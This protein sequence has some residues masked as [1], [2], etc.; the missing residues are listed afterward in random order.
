M[1]KWN[2]S[3][4]GENVVFIPPETK[5]P[6]IKIFFHVY[7][8]YEYL[9]KALLALHEVNISKNVKLARIYEI[10]TILYK[11]EKQRILN[12]RFVII[13]TLIILQENIK[14][15]RIDKK[16]YEK[17]KEQIKQSKFSKLVS[18]VHHTNIIKT[19]KFCYI[20]DFSVPSK[21]CWIKE[22]SSLKLLIKL[23]DGLKGLNIFELLPDFLKSKI[24][25]PKSDE[26]ISNSYLV[27]KERLLDK[28]GRLA[29]FWI[30]EIREYFKRFCNVTE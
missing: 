5:K 9:S 17:I 25:L 20:V 22:K 19:S 29:I 13:P 7:E 4:G 1:K 27:L 2:V 21:K 28:P 23:K 26:E 8:P 12:N 30:N 3:F 6:V 16:E 24:Y 11:S 18:D 10:R 14:G 15:S